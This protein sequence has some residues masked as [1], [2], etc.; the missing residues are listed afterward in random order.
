MAR[1]NG[2]M[3]QRRPAHRAFRLRTL[4]SPGPTA[5]SKPSKAASMAASSGRRAATMASAMIRCSSWTAS[6]APSARSAATKRRPTTTAPAPSAC[7]NRCCRRAIDD[8][9]EPLALY[10]H[11]PF[12]VTK[13]PYCDFNSHV[14]AT[15]DDADWRAALLAD[16]AHEAAQL[17]D[18]RLDSIFFGG[19]T[20]SLMPPETVA[21]L[22]DAATRH[23]QPRERPRNHPRSQPFSR[24]SGALCRL[25][26]RRRQPPQPGLAGARRCGSEAARPPARPCAGPGRA[27]CRAKTLRP[28]QLRPDLRPARHDGRQLAGRTRPRP[29]LRHRSSV[30]L[31]TDP[32]TRHP[33]HRAAQTGQIDP[34]R[35]RH[36]RRPV[37]PD[38]RHDRRRR[39]PR[40]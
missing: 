9:A 11:W 40:L 3:G 20:P 1:V 29:R 2:A 16:L 6:R 37:R 18:H 8:R 33:L 35:C 32:R 36:L 31:P 10:I 27:R 5:M 24:R 28:R 26:R 4:A 19:G 30:A 17:P 21:A 22:I 15:I 25:C 7:C 34:P 13:C 38:P 23:W 12:C 14:R 39:H